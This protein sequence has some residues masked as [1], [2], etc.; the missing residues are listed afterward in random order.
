[1]EKFQRLIN[2][3]RNKYLEKEFQKTLATD[4]Q[5]FLFWRSN[6]SYKESEQ[7]AI[8]RIRIKQQLDVTQKK[9]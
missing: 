6:H 3:P 4:N 9:L 5:I 7:K 1:M 8:I 2:H